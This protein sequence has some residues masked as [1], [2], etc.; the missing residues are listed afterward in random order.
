MKAFRDWD[1]AC[2]INAAILLFLLVAGGLI[3][4]VLYWK[5]RQILSEEVDTSARAAVRLA[6]ERINRDFPVVEA[7]A[8]ELALSIE[9]LR[10]D[11]A[12]QKAMIR[13]TLERLRKSV[14]ALCGISIAYIPYG[15]DPESRYYMLYTHVNKAGEIEVARIG[16]E[17][18]QYFKFDWFTI[19]QLL[20]RAVWTEPYL[21]LY[22]DILMS[23]RS[24]PIR[25]AGGKFIG[26]T[27]SRR[28]TPRLSLPTFT[29]T[30][31]SS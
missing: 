17:E 25:D 23:T 6:A 20:D 10:P 7:A 30:D 29:A 5:T 14:P 26:M 1:L 19:P 27:G 9:L 16:G 22:A 12:Q 18:Y 8:Q 2:K 11:E 24:Q 31:R 4:G 28:S 3:G 15:A 21:D 13:A